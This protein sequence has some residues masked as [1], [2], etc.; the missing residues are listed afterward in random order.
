[1]ARRMPTVRSAQ[2][3][4]GVGVLTLD[5]PPANAEDETLLA[6]LGRTLDEARADDAVRAVVLTGAGRFFS[7][8]FDLTAPR[9]EGEAVRR[10]GR[11]FRPTHLALLTF[12]QPP[13]P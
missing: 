10:I 6:D 3:D 1:A 9:R 13:L 11:L 12:P 4:G 8:G 7:A 2:G 5:R